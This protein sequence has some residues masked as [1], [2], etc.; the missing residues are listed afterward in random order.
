MA[1]EQSVGKRI[2]N[3]R[4]K[5]DMSIADLAEKSG[6]A[7][8]VVSA[9][10]KGGVMPALGV[11]T[12]LSRALGQRLGTFMD[13]QFKPDP[14]ITRAESLVSDELAK[15]GTNTLGYASHSLALGKP[16]RHMDPFRIEFAADGAD[17]TSSHE[18]EEL[19]ICLAG[20]VELTYG[21]E[22]TVLKPGDTAYYNSVV[23]HS[24]KALG[25]KPASIYGVVFMPF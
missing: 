1:K 7:A 25:G 2:Q 11:L 4:K 17:E 13:D 10:E 19:I 6:I 14:I 23:K 18:G 8:D 24:L 20:E 21:N 3:Y 15:A 12:K 9:I 22:K 5:L 16:D